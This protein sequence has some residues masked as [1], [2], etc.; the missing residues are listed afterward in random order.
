MGATESK[1]GNGI[2]FMQHFAPRKGIYIGTRE[3]PMNLVVV[4]NRHSC[5]KTSRSGSLGQGGTSCA[6]AGLTFR[7]ARVR[8]PAGQDRDGSERR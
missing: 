1:E 5:E 4:S 3:K 2:D 6:G 7:A 8:F